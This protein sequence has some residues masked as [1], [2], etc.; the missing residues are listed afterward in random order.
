MKKFALLTVTLLMGT[1]CFAQTKNLP[2]PNM[3][4]KTL[5]V[6]EAYQQRKSVR[7]YS[8]QPLSEQDL[9]D[10][11]WAA[12]GKNRA[13]G[14]L[15]AP[16]AMNRQEIRLYVFS[17][18]GVSLYDPQTHSLTQVAAGDHRDIVAGRQDFAKSAPVSL[19]M[20]ADMDKFGSNN[21]HAQWMVSVDTGIVCENI[22]LF[23][24]AA[25]LCTVPRGTMDA[26]A[27][28]SLLGL[29]DNQIPLI[30]NPVGYS[31]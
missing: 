19:V 16:T 8:A 17:E 26:K 7:E 1:S 28:Q 5:S 18:Q 12:Q 13:D 21:Q 10:L 24:S 15:T 9:S 31:K 22:N 27:I 20:V 25:G 29:T 14:H 23:C 3:Q 6:M 30:N 11:L 2:E 4:H